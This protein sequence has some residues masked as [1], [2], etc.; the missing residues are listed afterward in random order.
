MPL[1][2]GEQLESARLREP[3]EVVRAPGHGPIMARAPERRNGRVSLS[4]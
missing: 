4:A 3:S 2:L 1:D